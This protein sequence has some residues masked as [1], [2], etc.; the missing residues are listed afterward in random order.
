MGTQ[1]QVAAL[2]NRLR[3]ALPTED[4]DIS[5]IVHAAEREFPD[6]PG[7]IEDIVLAT[8]RALLESGEIIDAEMT[9]K[10]YVPRGVPP[11]D[12]VQR[13][14]SLW[15]ERGKPPT[16]ADMIWLVSPEVVELSRRS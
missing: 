1:E 6:F 3:P 11:A 10:G 8:V 16:I 7:D 14:R 9:A 4:V 15:D 5:F 12:T 13:I 2:A